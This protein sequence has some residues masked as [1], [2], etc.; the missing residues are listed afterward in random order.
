MNISAKEGAPRVSVI[1]PAYNAAA[2]V[3]EAIDSILAQ[4]FG[5]FELLVIDDGSSDDTL[6]IVSG[7]QDPR[8]K[9]L[10][11]ERNLGLVAA[12]NRG[13]AESQSEFI[14]RMD[15]DDISLP[16]RLAR[17]IEFLACQPRLGVI[18]CSY[19]D[20]NEIQGTLGTVALPESDTGIRHDLYCKS[21]CFC[22]PA[23]VMR[24]EALE[25][26][27]TY[28]AEWFPAEDRELWL[29]MLERW[30]GANVSQVLHR[31][32]RHPR[33]IT[34]Q[35]PLC[36]SDL[37]VASTVEALK[38]RQAP[39][40]VGDEVSKA[41]WSRGEL[42]AA[43]GLA[44]NKGVEAIKPHFDRAW[45]LDAKTA[46]C[47]F[48][49]LLRDR[50]AAFMHNHDADVDAARGLL[51]RVFAAL[52]AEL[53][54]F[55]ILQ[56]AMQAQV[57]AI[58]AFHEAQNRRRSQARRQAIQAIAMDRRQARNRGL[59]KLVLGIVGHRR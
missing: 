9:V 44:V 33:S 16:D 29:R 4:T 12:L 37:V 51:Q 5:D 46:S 17:Q 40:D 32:R 21:H 48:E 1:L 42:F 30:Q 19:E 6:A 23:V 10:R 31:M 41:A 18:S 3:G 28:R 49:E 26:V 38:R 52:P 53:D 57:H 50:I 47:S 13:I 24:R 14:A 56:P 8:L 55:G 45:A 43:F 22:H 20:F 59:V 54:H 35:N 58:A 11:N 15:A 7:F 39:P 34:S 36:Q 25:D 2:Y 27:G